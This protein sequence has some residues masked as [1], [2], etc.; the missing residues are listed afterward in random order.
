[1]LKLAVR[2]LAR[3]SQGHPQKHFVLHELIETTEAGIGALNGSEFLVSLHVL[4]W[5]DR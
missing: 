5:R 1:M 3:P 2:Y 4:P